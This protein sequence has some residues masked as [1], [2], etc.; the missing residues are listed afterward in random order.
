MN[1]SIVLVF[2]V[3]LAICVFGIEYAQTLTVMK[4]TTYEENIY[5][6]YSL[7][8][9]DTVGQI[10]NLAFS[11]EMIPIMYQNQTANLIAVE[12]LNLN[13]TGGK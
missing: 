3:A 1:L 12:C 7:G 6:S 5:N 13:Q 11:C 2:I 4:D 9:E 8:Y 10:A